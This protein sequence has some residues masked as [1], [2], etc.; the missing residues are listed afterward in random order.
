M[1]K[2][3]GEQMK[4]G[5]ISKLIGMGAVAL[6]AAS[7]PSWAA[8]LPS[9]KEP[10]VAPVV[11][12]NPPWFLRLGAGG[13]LFDSSATLTLAGATV[14]SASAHAGDNVT[15]IIEFGYY[16]ND[17]ISI[18]LTGGYPPTTTL[19]GTGNIAALGAL[20]KATY[21]PAVLTLD[22]HLK[23]FGAF[24]PYIG[25]GFVEAIIFSTQSRAVH[26][27]RIPS[28]GGWAVEGGFDYF[29]TPNWSIFADAKYLFL[30]VG[31]TG[32]VGGAP[33]TAHVRL[34]PIIVSTGLAYHW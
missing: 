9:V 22:Y 28:S 6:A 33:V 20:G 21:G 1:M 26:N 25:G 17:N 7:G 19:T 34:D 23:T 18:Q 11:A 14:P 13:V 12:Y 10:V 32:D 8:D 2:K 4:I 27:L 15:A 29:V 24:Q 16:I 3:R 31:A 30:T 5:T